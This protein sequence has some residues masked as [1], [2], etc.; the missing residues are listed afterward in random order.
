MFYS[1]IRLNECHF[2]VPRTSMVPKIIR[3][4]KYDIE[5]FQHRD[6]NPHR[7]TGSKLIKLG[8]LVILIN[9]KGHSKM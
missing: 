3:T 9:V 2:R 5:A 4:G 8:T 7:F 1:T 6:D